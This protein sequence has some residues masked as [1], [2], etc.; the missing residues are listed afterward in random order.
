MVAPLGCAKSNCDCVNSHAPS[1]GSSTA[2]GTSPSRQEKA[3][4]LEK[5]NEASAPVDVR[6]ATESEPDEAINEG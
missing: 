1:E 6:N 3:A 5:V 2:S 4:T